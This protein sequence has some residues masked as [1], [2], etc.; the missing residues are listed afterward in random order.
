MEKAMAQM[1]PRSKYSLLK[2]G[3]DSE[4]G[5]IEISADRSKSQKSCNV[6]LSIAFQAILSLLL[7]LVIWS[8]LQK[9]PYGD[10]ERC[11]QET[12]A[13]KPNSVVEL[14]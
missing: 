13:R 14:L 7:A 10:P 2:D 11:K 5:T 6:Y 4:L 8:S 12:Q 3:E 1:S 9:C